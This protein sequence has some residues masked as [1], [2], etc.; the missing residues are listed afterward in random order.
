VLDKFEEVENK[1][2]NSAEI[3]HLVADD[4]KGLKSITEFH[5]ML[6]EFNEIWFDS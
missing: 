4:Y 6:L 2:E 1:Q 5:N 3:Y